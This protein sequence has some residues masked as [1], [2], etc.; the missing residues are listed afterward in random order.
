[1]AHAERAAAAEAAVKTATVA[2]EKA[3]EQ[4]DHQRTALA[5]AE[6]EGLRQ[7]ELVERLKRALT[8]R[9]DALGALQSRAEELE[10]AIGEWQRVE[11]QRLRTETA[12][13][14]LWERGDDHR[15]VAEAVDRLIDDMAEAEGVLSRA[16]R[17]R[18]SAVQST[19]QLVIKAQD[20]LD[21]RNADLRLVVADWWG[22]DSSD[23]TVPLI[24]LRRL[25]AVAEGAAVGATSAARDAAVAVSA[26]RE[27]RLRFV[28]DLAKAR[29]EEPSI[30]DTTAVVLSGLRE[31]VEEHPAAGP[32]VVDDLLA[33]L[34][35]A[36]I[37]G[38]LAAVPDIVGA[39][40]LVYLTNDRR[41]L[42]WAFALP[43]EVGGVTAAVPPSLSPTA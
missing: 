33:D 6:M 5:T 31:L 42:A 1:T 25:K 38:V 43:A 22:G 19:Q 26:A 11:D 16:D 14:A 3:V 7:A 30:P 18:E 36:L 39:R 21:R 20:E 29:L 28:D 37:D 24:G 13:V 4:L 40:G 15:M 2:E 32:V 9:R 35:D 27:Q 23:Q 10:E 17:R 34:D 8:A 12:L 41:V